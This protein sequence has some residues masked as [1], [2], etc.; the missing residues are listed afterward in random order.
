MGESVKKK[1]G[2][3]KEKTTTPA[4]KTEWQRKTYPLKLK[5]NE[6][7]KQRLNA[8]L[9]EYKKTTQFVID[10]CINEIFPFYKKL[11]E[12]HQTGK[13]PL[14]N[15]QKE[16]KYEW[17]TPKGKKSKNCGCLNGHYSLRKLFLPS[18]THAI[19]NLSIPEY[20]MRF[21]GKL[22]D[23]F[24]KMILGGSDLL[25]GSKYN[26]DIYDSCLQKA[27]ETIKSQNALNKKIDHEIKYFTRRNKEIKDFLENE[28]DEKK[29]KELI[30][31]LQSYKKSKLKKF[32]NDNNKKLR[33]LRNKKAEKVEF[34][35]NMARLYNTFYNWIEKEKG[36]FILQITAFAKPMQIDFF[37]DNYQKKKAAQFVAQEKQPEIELLRRKENHFIQYIYRKAPSI[38]EPDETFTAVGID[39]GLLNHYATACLNKDSK[40][41]FQIRFF[42]GRPL[43]RK[44]RQYYKIRRIW[45]KKT[46]S[47]KKGGR[48]RSEGWYKKKCKSQNE[49]NFVKTELHKVSA[50]VA[51]HIYNNAKNPVIVLEDLK[52]IRD[53]TN[54]MKRSHLLTLKK[55]LKGPTKKKYLRER[56]LNKELNNWNFENL[57]N[58]LKYKAE[59]LGIPVVVLPAKNT[60]IK[61]TKCGDIDEK[62]YFDLHQLWFN[63]LACGYKCNIDFNAAVNLAKDFFLTID[64]LKKMQSKLDGDLTEQEERHLNLVKRLNPTCFQKFFAKPAIPSP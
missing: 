11:K 45:S 17:H 2:K 46:K 22:Y 8:F 25:T 9:D 47:K 16:L 33:R 30:N 62:N 19:T 23:G 61:C 10:K 7:Q 28:L 53:E 15:K 40:K 5:L 57:H 13:C 48:G 58:F 26:H 50:K 24:P 21:A 29:D 32:I 54:K 59:W 36:N 52:N 43:R 37:G 63:C 55:K 44:R 41:P 49:K 42:N 4:P 64:F 1:H 14:C 35:G 38:P 6:E 27:C 31:K 39:V 51:Q 34:K 18:K 60:S 3:N 12:P 20:D 56:Y